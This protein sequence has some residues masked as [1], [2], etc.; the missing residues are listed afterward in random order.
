MHTKSSEK[1]SLGIE[2]K[3][4]LNVGVDF[5]LGFEIEDQVFTVR[6]LNTVGERGLD[7]V[8]KVLMFW[9]RLL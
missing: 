3:E 8:L 9:M 4:G 7:I 1:G 6:D 2:F 5:V